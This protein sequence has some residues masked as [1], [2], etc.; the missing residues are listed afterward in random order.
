VLEHEG[1]GFERLQRVFFEEPG[2]VRAA[3]FRRPENVS[4]ALPCDQ[5]KDQ[6]GQQ[7][8]C[9]QKGL[10]RPQGSPCLYIRR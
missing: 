8:R 4:V 10:K 7:D 5:G 3:A 9:E 2:D 6:H 1:D